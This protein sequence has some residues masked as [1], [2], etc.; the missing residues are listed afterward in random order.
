MS[1]DLNNVDDG[2]QDE[3]KIEITVPPVE[4]QV[5]V[6]LRMVLQL[7]VDTD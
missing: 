5:M 2:V 6:I 7:S 3:D 4:V 1:E